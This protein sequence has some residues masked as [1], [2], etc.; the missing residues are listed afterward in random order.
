[1]GNLNNIMVALAR[2]SSSL[3]KP[4]LWRYVLAPA[5][6]SLVLWLGLAWWGLPDMRAWLLEHSPLSFLVGWNMPVL[7]N[8][9][10]YLAGWAAILTLAYITAVLIA[11]LFVLPLLLKKVA[12]QQ[13]TELAALGSDNFSKAAINSL[14]AT[15]ILILGWIITL[16]F[17]LIPGFG[18]VMPLLLLAWFNRKTFA[19]DC[20]AAYATEEEWAS[21]RHEH[22][23]PLFMLGLVLALLAHIPILGLLV[24]VLSA[25]AYIHYC[26]EALRRLRNGALVA[27]PQGEAQV[28]KQA[29]KS[30]DKE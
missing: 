6:L 1:M 17:W 3:A 24:P 18:V 25:L 28:E 29:E 19:F 23:W 12:E 20:L 21:I 8:F 30:G 10:A 5:L 16:P 7:A 13:Y 11:A 14:I 15:G 22:R 2:S 27:I 4:G 9:I 26:L